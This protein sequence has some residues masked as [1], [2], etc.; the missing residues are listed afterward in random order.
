MCRYFAC[1]FNIVNITITHYIHCLLDD[2]NEMYQ[3]IFPQELY[4]YAVTNL[5]FY[6]LTQ[7]DKK[8]TRAIIHYNHVMI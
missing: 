3:N 7:P 6:W 4:K 1:L 2:V 8:H 5:G